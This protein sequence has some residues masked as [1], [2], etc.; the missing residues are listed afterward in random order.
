MNKIQYLVEDIK[1]DLNEEDSQ[2][3]AIFHSLLKKL[4]SLLII[5]SVPMFIYLLF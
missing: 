2:I 3:L 5:S 1:V 4:F